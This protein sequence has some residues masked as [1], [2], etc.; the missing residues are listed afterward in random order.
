MLSARLNYKD[1]SPQL[2]FS[3]ETVL[4]FSLPDIV[5]LEETKSVHSLLGQP[6]A[7]QVS[8]VKLFKLGA[9]SSNF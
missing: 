2:L 9:C 8:I 3:Q 4:S 7:V 5:C 6:T 1:W